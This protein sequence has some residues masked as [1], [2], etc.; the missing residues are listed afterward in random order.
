MGEANIYNLWALNF[1][2]GFSK[3]TLELLWITAHF[4]KSEKGNRQLKT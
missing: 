2:I 3:N 4:V 1:T